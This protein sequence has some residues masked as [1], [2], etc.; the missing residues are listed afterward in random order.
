MSSTIG[1][2]DKNTKDAKKYFSSPEGEKRIRELLEEA[3][4]EEEELRRS[5]RAKPD[6]LNKT[7][8]PYYDCRRV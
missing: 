4:K 1:S 8:N 3:R 6:Q 2:L 5:Y 7:I